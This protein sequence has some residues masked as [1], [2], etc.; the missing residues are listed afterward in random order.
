MATQTQLRNRPKYCPSRPHDYIYDPVY[1]VSGAKDHRRCV[2]RA[3]RTQAQFQ[4]CPIFPTMFS[5]LC[6]RTSLALKCLDR[7]PNSI[8][9]SWSA[10]QRAMAERPTR[11]IDVDGVDRHHFFRRPII[12]LL[13]P[14]LPNVRFTPEDKLKEEERPTK[15]PETRA[16]QTDYRESETQTIPWAPPHVGSSEVLTLAMLSWGH[17]LPAGVHEVEIIQ[18]ARVRRA[19]EGVDT[20][21]VL[22][23]VERDEWAFRER[24]IQE[25]HDMRL[26]LAKG[27]LDS[28]QRG[29]SERLD[30]RLDR[31][32]A[33]KQRE[34]EERLKAI[35]HKYAREVRK[36]ALRHSGVHKKY[37]RLNVVE[38]H[39]DITSELYGPQT[40]FGED[41]RRRN[42]LISVDTKILS[43]IKGTEVLE[44]L[45]K[46]KP[47]FDYE[48][49]SVPKAHGEL[50]IRETRWTEDMLRKLHEDLGALRVKREVP[51]HSMHLVSKVEELEERPLTPSTE[52]VLDDDES[53]YQATVFFQKVI[54]GRAVQTLMSR[55][56]SRCHELIQELKTTQ[57]LQDAGMS[58]INEE[59]RSVLMAQRADYVNRNKEELV[60][61]A[62]D[63]ITGENVATLLDLLSKEL[64]R[65]QDERKAHA[66]AILATRERH[67]REAAEAGRRQ[68]EERRRREHDEM[69]K[70]TLKVHQDTVDLYLEDVILDA[71]DW[72]SE[73]EARQHV[74]QMARRIDEAAYEAHSRSGYLEQ[75]EMVADMIHNYV[76]PE[77]QKRLVRDKMERRQ[78]KY[79]SEAHDTIYQKME[80][81]DESPP[82]ERDKD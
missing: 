71:L 36:L 17:G 46:P 45:K 47:A 62:V 43:Q 24:E 30:H 27:L 18:R 1:T 22:H 69:F 25:I 49:M 8:D 6:P 50:C 44:K 10:K 63:A 9:K 13:H 7:V 58:E 68:A 53:T 16:T 73:Q 81:L 55:G 75:E 12:P 33:Y 42:E 76:L 15:G 37:R 59:R 31:Y 77:V 38:E 52:V 20:E 70:Q 14:I 32:W 54:K 2:M 48:K 40:R 64:C 21:D 67:R 41:P 57:A 61:E 79:L 39:T 72:V 78:K 51:R 82:E 4:V 29:W 56:S 28:V 3:A 80:E 65:L 19:W 26:E 35:R 5:D 74:R 60:L 34:K 66:F 11:S 23:A